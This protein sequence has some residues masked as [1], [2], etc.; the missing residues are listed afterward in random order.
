MNLRTR[1][2][3]PDTLRHSELAPS[4]ARPVMQV[5]PEV[6]RWR[7]GRRYRVK[8]RKIDVMFPYNLGCKLHYIVNEY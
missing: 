3:N 5:F 4:G 2:F 8:R 1:Y 7:V 6:A